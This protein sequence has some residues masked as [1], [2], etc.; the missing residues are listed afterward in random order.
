MPDLHHFLTPHK[1]A[2]ALAAALAVGAAA[3]ILLAARFLGGDAGG[4]A[5]SSPAE[6]RAYTVRVIEVSP[7]AGDVALRYTGLVQPAELVQLTASTV[8]KI[9]SIRVAE[10]EAVTAGQLLAELD[11]SDAA[12]Q[13]ENSRQLRDS[14]ARTLEN[15]QRSHDRALEDYEYACAGASEEELA[16]A[17]GRLE[18]ARTRE[19]EAQ[20]NLASINA[21]LAAQQQRVDAAQSRLDAAQ[22]AYDTAL[23]AQ[24]ERVDAAEQALSAARED[25][26]SAPGDPALTD[27]V[28]KAEEA[29]AAEQAALAAPPAGSEL[30]AAAASLETARTDLLN[31]R[32]ALVSLQTDLGLAN[33]QAELTAAGSERAA[34][35]TAYDTLKAQG[36]DST[37]AKAQKE[38]LEAADTALAQ[39]QSSYNVAQSNYESALA[40]LEDYKLYAPSA[41]YVVTLVG[42]EGSLATPLAPVLVLGSRD[43]VVRFGVSQSDV[44]ELT[45]DMPAAVTLDGESYAGRIASIAVLPDETTRTYPV[46]VS[47]GADSGEVY[48][49][50]MASVELQLGERTGVWLPLSVI[51]NDGE[52]YVYLVEDGRAVRRN[53]GI[54][55]FSNDMVLVTGVHEGGL[56]ISEGMKTVRSGSP[57]EVLDGGDAVPAAPGVEPAGSA[58]LGGE[59]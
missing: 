50:S 21:A 28:Q 12:R 1:K 59:G 20:Q 26:A 7:T 43:T 14:A 32:T 48:L 51:L 57:V 24:Q 6:E 36:E 38:R 40:A 19:S 31:E 16:G 45:T 3:G 23:A 53:V 27:A 30:A 39:A 52:D 10:G 9:T 5:A 54:A 11:D 34:A 41:G 15:A 13:A 37:E 17:R 8:G 18:S 49:G 2:A 33:A 29:L 44:R 42:S 22:Q 56:V 35:Q 25:L 55:E 4:A 47:I 58:A 46:D